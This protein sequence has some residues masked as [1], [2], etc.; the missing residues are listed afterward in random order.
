MLFLITLL[1]QSSLMLISPSIS[2]KAPS[3]LVVVIQR[4]I[5]NGRVGC[6]SRLYSLNIHPYKYQRTSSYIYQ[7]IPDGNMIG[8]EAVGFAY[9]ANPPVCN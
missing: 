4:I 7:V 6:T 1:V 8:R 2:P 5:N 3:H 9:R